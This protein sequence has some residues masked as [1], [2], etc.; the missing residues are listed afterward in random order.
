MRVVSIFQPPGNAKTRE[1]E[2]APPS[3][4][5]HSS[6]VCATTGSRAESSQ[7]VLRHASTPN[8]P[9]VNEMVLLAWKEG[10]PISRVHWPP[11]WWAELVC[12]SCMEAPHEREA[13]GC[14]ANIPNRRGEMECCMVSPFLPPAR[15][16]ILRF[17]IRCWTPKNE[18]H[19]APHDASAILEIKNH[20]FNPRGSVV[21]LCSAS[22]DQPD[23]RLNLGP[24]APS[25]HDNDRKK[26]ARPR[27]IRN[28]GTWFIDP[29]SDTY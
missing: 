22:R 3:P 9:L 8:R 11:P 24:P 21:G 12:N 19:C 23:G 17:K 1:P 4:A 13:P 29:G 26:P 20:R 6:Q 18:P 10:A 5:Y 2:L 28:K 7:L 27:Q 16:G 15:T 14:G 25:L